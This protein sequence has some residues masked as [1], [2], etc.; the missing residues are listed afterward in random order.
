[1][2][3]N[4]VR[5]GDE[6]PQAS[7]WKSSHGKTFKGLALIDF[8]LPQ[9]LLVRSAANVLCFWTARLRRKPNGAAYDPRKRE[10]PML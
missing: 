3:L 4:L 9:G 2:T 5:A 10:R 8:R 7:R 6:T 1:M